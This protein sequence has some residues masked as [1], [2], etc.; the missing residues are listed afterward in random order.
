MMKTR[1]AF[2]L[3]FVFCAQTLAVT[4][5]S[6]A[7]VYNR[8]RDKLKG[9][10]DYVKRDIHKAGNKTIEFET[11]ISLE[12]DIKLAPEIIGNI[13]DYGKWALN[14]VNKKP[15]GGH[16]FLQFR[17]LEEK[18]PHSKILRADVVIVLPIFEKELQRDF[19]LETSQNG[20]VLTLSGEALPNENSPIATA[21]G[22]VR[23]YP[24]EGMSGR[25]WIYV[26]GRAQLRSWIL[27][28]AIP[29]RLM[30]GETGER[31]MIMLENYLVEEERLRELHA[32]SSAVDSAKAIPSR[33][34]TEKKARQDGMGMIHP[35]K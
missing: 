1:S 8:V 10:G 17:S 22:F 33:I 21:E 4:L 3:L 14:G 20:D 34:P 18:P 35:Q 25:V 32:K 28:E 11:F 24:A 19:K 7:E 2:L 5:P 13:A 15:S 29:E 31:I 12:G 26:K 23:I 9:Q 30:F 6:D 16:Y 27:Y